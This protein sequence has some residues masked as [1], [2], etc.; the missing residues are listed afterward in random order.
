MTKFPTP[1]KE[2]RFQFKIPLQNTI[3]AFY[4]AR[5]LVAAHAPQEVHTPYFGNPQTSKVFFKAVLNSKV[6]A[7]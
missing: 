3:H 7:S 1:I 6:C 2:G 4:L 5:P